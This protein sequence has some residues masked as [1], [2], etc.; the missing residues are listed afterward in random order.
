[1]VPMTDLRLQHYVAKRASLSPGSRAAISTDRCRYADQVLSWA[2]T[3]AP[4]GI[5]PGLPYTV[6]G[7]RI[8]GPMVG[9]GSIVLVCVFQAGLLTLPMRAGMLVERML[10]TCSNAF[11][12]S[13]SS[14]VESKKF[15]SS[16]A[17]ACQCFVHVDPGGRMT[18]TSSEIH[19]YTRPY[20]FL[21]DA[22]GVFSRVVHIL[23]G[24]SIVLFLR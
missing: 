7:R 6:F 11:K 14:R 9:L 19:G 17:L 1:M 13:S 18:H 2:C 5:M 21:I 8:S 4:S 3:S 16:Q 24:F 23:G 10:S 15:A 20:V 22:I 12:A